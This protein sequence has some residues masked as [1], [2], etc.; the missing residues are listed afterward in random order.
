MA[1]EVWA[2]LGALPP[3]QRAVLVQR[4]VL[5]LSEAEMAAAH[6]RPPGTI[7]SRLHAARGRLRTLLR[8]ASTDGEVLP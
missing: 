1:G 2:A 4:Y 7:K 8:P 5:G 6:D 3:A